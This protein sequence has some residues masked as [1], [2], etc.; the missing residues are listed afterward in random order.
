MCKTISGSFNC[1]CCWFKKAEQRV[2]VELVAQH[3]F[4][5][6]LRNSKVAG[7]CKLHEQKIESLAAKVVEQETMIKMLTKKADESAAQVQFIACRA[8]DTSAQRF[9]FG[10]KKDAERTKETV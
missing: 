1:S 7:E 3:K 9:V 10:D 2:T 6:E 4:D 5:L 8:L